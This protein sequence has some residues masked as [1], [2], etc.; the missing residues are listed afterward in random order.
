MTTKKKTKQCPNW[1]I[2]LGEYTLGTIDARDRVRLER[3]LS[4]CRRCRRALGEMEALYQLMGPFQLARPARSF[5][6]RLAA[7]VQKETAP[8]PRAPVA[9]GRTAVARPARRWWRIPAFASAFATAAIVLI[10]FFKVWAPFAPAPEVPITAAPPATEEVAPAAEGP[11]VPPA[12]SPAPA[13]PPVAY[14]LAETAAAAAPP[15]PAEPLSER[16][17]ADDGLMPVAAG[18]R[19][20]STP[21]FEERVDLAMA[22][23]DEVAAKKKAETPAPAS[24]AFAWGEGG[25]AGAAGVARGSSSGLGGVASG[26]KATAAAVAL[27]GAAATD[28]DTVE[29]WMDPRVGADV[30]R[31]TTDDAALLDYATPNGSL[32]VYF[33]ELSPEEQKTVLTRLRA[34]TEAAPAA[35]LLNT[36]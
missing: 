12:K 31:L 8:A 9:E 33:M 5:R 13:Q 1:Q 24:A 26:T 2:L 30:E 7:A 14:R 36:Y 28:K 4:A 10:L 3:H 23:A 16:T 18:S 27:T 6:G 25:G 19:G 15:A 32:V 34:E 17:L 21:A 29:D 22:T 35:E 11:V 20:R